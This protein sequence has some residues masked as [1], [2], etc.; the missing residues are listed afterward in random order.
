MIDW[1]TDNNIVTKNKKVIISRLSSQGHESSRDENQEE[2]RCELTLC[3]DP[4]AK[5]NRVLFFTRDGRDTQSQTLFTSWPPQPGI[6]LL[7]SMDSSLQIHELYAD[8]I[9]TSIPDL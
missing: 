5:T 6:F 4:R 9:R 3:P 1:V 8:P 7:S 2:R